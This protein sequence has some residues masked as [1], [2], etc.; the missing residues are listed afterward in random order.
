VEY[1]NS[2]GA[3]I[4]YARYT[5]EIKSSI[6]MAREAFNKKKTLFTSK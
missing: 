3:M 1:L 5:L 2:L 4:N 6:S